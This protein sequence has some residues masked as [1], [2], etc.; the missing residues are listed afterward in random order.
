MTA[1]AR[2]LVMSAFVA[3]AAAVSLASAQA[4]DAVGAASTQSVFERPN[5]SP[6]RFTPVGADGRAVLAQ[7]C[8]ARGEACTING[9]PCCAA[10]E[11]KGTF[12]YTSCQ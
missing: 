9:T 6:T 11:C 3:T 2:L 12:P 1:L 7:Q 8:I 10:S 5:T 4:Q